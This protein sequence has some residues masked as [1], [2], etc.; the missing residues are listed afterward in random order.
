MNFHLDNITA[1]TGGISLTQPIF[2]GGKIFYS[3]KKADLGVQMAENGYQLK[4]H[5]VIELTDQAFWQA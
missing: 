4:Y 3:N 1:Y 5:E 2:T